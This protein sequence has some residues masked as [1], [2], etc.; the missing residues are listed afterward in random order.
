VTEIRVVVP[1]EVAQPFA[2]RALKSGTTPEQLA[3]EVVRSLVGAPAQPPGGHR[4]GLIATGR[5]GGH[6]SV[7][8]GHEETASTSPTRVPQMPDEVLLSHGPAAPLSAVVAGGCPLGARR[9][10]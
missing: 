10:L 2:E 3:G 7:A 4:S 5:S 8:E 1:D 6:D 9:P